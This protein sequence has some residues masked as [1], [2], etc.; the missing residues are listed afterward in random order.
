LLRI[1]RPEGEK[2]PRLI[3][4]WISLVLIT[5]AV[6]VCWIS[7]FT[8]PQTGTPDWD[9]HFARWAKVSIAIALIGI[10]VGVVS[11]GRKRGVVIAA[12]VTVPL[13]WAL[14]KILE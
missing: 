10:I 7:V 3:F 1:V 8:A 14:A 2:S 12:G 5:F 6:V 11:S 13:F 4:G 9:S